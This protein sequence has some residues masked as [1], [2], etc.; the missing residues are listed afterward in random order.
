MV[1]QP[2]G[3]REGQLTPMIER[4]TR[5]GWARGFFAL[6]LV[7]T[8]LATTTV[9]RDTV[10][11]AADEPSA[12]QA[13]FYTPPTDGTSVTT[14]ATT[15][16]FLILTEG[17]ER[18]RNSLR[19]AGYGGQVLQYVV[20]SESEGPGPYANSSAACDASYDPLS[21]QAADQ[22]GDFCK[23]LHPNESWFLHNGAGKR[24]Y[25]YWDGRLYYHM[26]PASSG[27]RNFALTRMK[28]DLS[29][30]GY[31]G[32]FLD[33]VE[34]S[35]GKVR[36]QLA[37]SDGV[38]K[39]FSGDAALRDAWAGYLATLSAG[40]RSNGVL[41]ANMVADLN[42]GDTWDL[43]LQH[44]DGGMFE[45]FATG[46]SG[47]T[48]ARWNNNLRQAESALANGK[49]VLMVGRGSK[50]DSARQQ[51]AF[52]SY[53]LVTTGAEAYFR[54]GHS[55]SYG[56]WWQY[57]NYDVALGDP[58]GP[59]YAVGAN[60][61]RDFDCG[62]VVV[63]PVAR[64]GQIVET[65]CASQ[66]QPPVVT[67]DGIAD[68]QTV[69]GTL[70]AQALVSAT[71]SV[72]KVEFLLDGQSIDLEYVAPYWLGGD[73]G[74]QPLGID[75][76]TWAD[77]P[78][79]LRAIATDANGLT[80]EAAVSF[81]VTNTVAARPE[82]ALAGI[83]NGDV[84]SGTINVEA[85]V[86]SAVPVREVRFLLDGTRI[87]VEYVAP[88]WLGGDSGG[89]PRGVDTRAWSNGQ[90]TLRARVTDVNGGA[91]SIDVTFTVQN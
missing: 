37:N 50:S 12:R 17:G 30:L 31:D 46:Y 52:A 80:G 86:S 70:A 72:R 14:M 59:R 28:A 89:V 9:S 33:N 68:G 55:G 73:S 84:V 88:Y 8:T 83:A 91:R 6:A 10:V 18:Y 48:A 76:R 4:T 49:G 11:R 77:G 23:H 43:Y 1:R 51:F 2:G 16:R 90:H 47:L 40:L 13:Y 57:A 66:A 20:A 63:D 35:M 78:H 36:A 64:S 22:V 44:L 74:G 34:L 82:I 24:L 5:A 25:H 60:W 42:N 3:P 53:L 71:A 69:S 32:I 7:L 29:S 39:E 27:W 58:L 15:S 45:A 75:T 41:W 85:I 79:E 62:Y 19:S 61:R 21:N 67:I 87:H 38:V 81:T 56:Q 65:A 26:N 54:Y